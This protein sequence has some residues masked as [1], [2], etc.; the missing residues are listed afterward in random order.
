MSDVEMERICF[1]DTSICVTSRVCASVGS[2]PLRAETRVCSNSL[3]TDS[4]SSDTLQVPEQT[5]DPAA[6]PYFA[7]ITADA[8]T[9]QTDVGGFPSNR[10]MLGLKIK[11]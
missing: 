6:I 10:I 7:R 4:S 8:G 9:E 5:L 1:G 11:F 2:T 3:S